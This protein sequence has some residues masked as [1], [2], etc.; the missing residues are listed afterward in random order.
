MRSVEELIKESVAEI[1]S[2]YE[3]NAKGGIK[4]IINEIV[5]QQDIIKTAEKA[6]KDLQGALKGITVKQVPSN[7]LV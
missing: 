2:D 6:I 4:H 1:N 3:F 5:R 7:F